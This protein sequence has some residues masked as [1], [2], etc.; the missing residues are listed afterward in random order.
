MNKKITFIKILCVFV[1]FLGVVNWGVGQSCNIS[2]SFSRPDNTL[3]DSNWIEV[4]GN[5]SIVSDELVIGTGNL[6]GI[7]YVYQD[8]STSYNT[9]LSS[10]P[11]IITWTF[12][13]QQSRNPLN[14]PSG[15]DSNNYGIAFILG[16]SSSDFTTGNGYAVVLGES[17]D[18]DDIRLVSYSGGLNLNS[19]LTD[20]IFGITDYDIE[21]FSIK[22]TYDPTSNIWE[23]FVRNDGA[24][25]SNPLSLTSAESV[26]TAINSTYTSSNLNNIGMLWNH[27]SGASET[28]T[29]DNICIYSDISCTSSTT[30][31]LG[32]W[33]NGT[34]DLYTNVLI[35]D[36]Y[37]TEFNG[38]FSS[39]SL[40]VKDGF[41]LNIADGNYVEVQNNLTVNGNVLVQPQGSF[42]QNN[43][44]GLVNG[45]VLSDKTK[46]VI[47]KK[48]APMNYWYEY[49]YW[50]S[51]VSGEI[52]NEGLAE[53]TPNRRFWFNAQNYL[54][55]CY[56]VNNDNT[57]TPGQDDIDDNAPYD[58]TLTD[59]ADEMLQGVGYAS[60]H[61]SDLFFAPPPATLPYQ[62][63][64][65]FEGPFNNGIITVPVYR[66]DSELNDINWNLIGNPYPSA[67]SADDFFDLNVYDS[68]SNPNG[69]LEGTIYLWSQ[70]TAPSATANGNQ[71]LN[72][73]DLDYAIINGTGEIEGGDRIK[74]DRFI[75]SGQGFF[76]SVSDMATVIDE[77]SN[78]DPYV[79]TADVLF[80]N[81]MRAT[82]NNNLFFKTSNVKSS[83]LKSDPNKLWINLTAD[84]GVFNQVLVGYVDGA[85]NE[86]DGMYYDVPRIVTSRTA[87]ALY[88]LISNDKSKYAIQGKEPNS[89]NLGEVIPLG[90]YTGITGATLYKLSIAQFEGNFF[91]TNMV[92]LKDNLMH[93]V[94]NLSESDYTF[95]SEVG[96]FNSR[97]EIVFQA[98]TLSDIE[99][100]INSNKLTVIELNDGRV[101]FKT[102]NNFTI[103]TVKIFD[104]L[105]R[106][107]YQLQGSNTTEIYNLTYLSQSAYIAK[108][109]LS[110]G[111]IVTK[112]ALKRI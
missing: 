42:V 94:H 14:G 46:I 67:I 97:F 35:N 98:Q 2:D 17:L 7:D 108:V 109:E 58:W 83:K 102:N 41:T 32:D 48:T 60:T 71:K 80:N 36:D 59:G 90:F 54:D 91:N 40:I 100:Q 81:S 107:L 28:A 88:S 4:G 15:F 106:S 57:C 23:L 95:T 53:A 68:S 47:N 66:N 76:V 56:E 3:I 105:G 89:L 64:Y 110:N 84:I 30:W 22:V 24:T 63:D 87:S 49:T 34:P 12:N 55:A 73:S 70:N 103:K 75:P 92:Y 10:L 21:H 65:T 50:S 13:M 43:D 44:D 33:T 18:I 39:C 1:T 16:G 111:Q 19:N 25:F 62:F 74:P 8:V 6:K 72:F 85:T 96:E 78:P 104:V 52:I 79:K 9:Q 51:P 27:S 82:Q 93:K 101:Q 86:F 99:A 112:K 5:S 31:E 20:I 11:S 37:D 29:F 77:P 61:R 45:A 26:G 69:T 38:S